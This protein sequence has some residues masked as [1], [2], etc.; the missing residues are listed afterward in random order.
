MSQEISVSDLILEKFLEHR[1]MRAGWI[2]AALEREY[3]LDLLESEISYC[4]NVLR[5]RGC[6][7]YGNAETGWRF[8]AEQS[9]TGGAA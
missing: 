8:V 4:I 7:I 5:S 6:H 3:G 2:A 9:A 1:F